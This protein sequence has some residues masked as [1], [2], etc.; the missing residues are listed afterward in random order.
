MD[1]HHEFLSAT[2]FNRYLANPVAEAL[3]FRVDHDI[4]PAHLVMIIF[5]CLALTILAL[6]LK[7]R[8]SVDNPGSLQQMF[9]V[10]CEGLLGLMEEIIGSDAKRYFHVIGALFLYILA[11]NLLGLFPGFMPPT[12][13]FNVTAACGI[14]VFL[15]YNFHGFRVHGFVKYMA[16][17][18]GPSLVIAPVLFV[19][20]IISHLARP[21]SLSV[22]LMGNIYAEELI[23]SN[24]NQLFPFLI[25]VPVMALGLFA[26]ILQAFIF[27]VLTIVYIAASVEHA[28]DED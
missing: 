2:L 3:G 8:L 21:F 27:S 7:S 10:L 9:E 12:S 11:G 18:A 13:N 16:H 6:F 24:L 19:I 4:F 20:E 15:Y 14:I 28:H 26:G 22:R 5:V 25:S 23:V 17:F 1:P